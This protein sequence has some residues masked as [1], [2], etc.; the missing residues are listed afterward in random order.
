MVL[1][2]LFVKSLSVESS[3]PLSTKK[4]GG[5]VLRARAV[6]LSGSYHRHH[7]TTS[8]TASIFTLPFY[9]EINLPSDYLMIINRH[10]TS[11]SF[12][13]PSLFWLTLPLSRIQTDGLTLVPRVVA[14]DVNSPEPCLPAV[15]EH[16]G[17]YTG[18]PLRQASLSTTIYLR[19]RLLCLR[20]RLLWFSL[21]AYLRFL[22]KLS[23]I[24]SKLSIFLS[25]VIFSQLPS[26]AVSSVGVFITAYWGYIFLVSLTL[27][28]LL[29]TAAAWTLLACYLCTFSLQATWTTLRNVAVARQGQLTI[30]E[31]LDSIRGNR[32]LEQSS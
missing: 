14:E 6:C 29:E 11:S 5:F 30:R 9:R 21:V 27:I 7:F 28:E 18:I 31:V 12:L 4:F 16:C 20:L 13:F 3:R 15:C 10:P 24:L 32:A 1:Q 19:L 26:L 25:Y 8:I 23:I 22:A 17:G 2:I